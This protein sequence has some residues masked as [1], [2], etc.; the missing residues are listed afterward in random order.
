M[1][2]VLWALYCLGEE[3]H[4]AGAGSGLTVGGWVSYD[5]DQ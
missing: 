1:G 4:M 3:S 2:G 5:R